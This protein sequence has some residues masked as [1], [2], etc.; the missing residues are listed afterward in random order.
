LKK[1]QKSKKKDLISFYG[2]LKGACGDGMEYQQNIRNGRNS[3]VINKQHP[4]QNFLKS[5]LPGE[6]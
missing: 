4:S 3:V 5:P 1:L 2:K 6:I